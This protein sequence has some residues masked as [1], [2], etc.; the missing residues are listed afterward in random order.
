MESEIQRIK[1]IICSEMGI[2]VSQLFGKTRKAEIVISRQ[3]LAYILRKKFNLS[4]H[5]IGTEIKKD[6][7]TAIHAVKCVEIY[8]KA[9]KIIAKNFRNI[10]HKI[11]DIRQIDETEILK[12]ENAELKSKISELEKENAELKN[13]DI[14]YKLIHDLQRQV[15]FYKKRLELLSQAKTVNYNHG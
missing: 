9:D 5:R 12:K 11:N 6:H 2:K 1:E 15:R 4:Y 3:I 13:I 14:D 7:A 10:E 8:L